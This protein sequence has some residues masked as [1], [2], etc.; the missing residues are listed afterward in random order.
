MENALYAS[1]DSKRNL[2]E[3]N[4]KEI[5]LKLSQLKNLNN[6]KN[7]GDY[8]KQRLDQILLEKNLFDNRNKARGFIIAGKVI[9]NNEKL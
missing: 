6:F 7:R 2:Q 8:M 4:K 9:I 3:L 1:L 5:N